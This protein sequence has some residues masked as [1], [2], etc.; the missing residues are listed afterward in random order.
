MRMVAIAM[1]CLLVTS[2]AYRIQ[3]RIVPTLA[4]IDRTAAYLKVHMRNGD[5][6]VLDSWALDP[7]GTELVGHGEYRGPDRSARGGIMPYRIALGEVA[8]CETNTKPISPADVPMEILTGVSLVLSVLGIAYV[9]AF[10]DFAFT[11]NT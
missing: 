8:V 7:S 11:S 4:Q 2:C 1:A 5:V 9:A 6:Y 10:L 3:R